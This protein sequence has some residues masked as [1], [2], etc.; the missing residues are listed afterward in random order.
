MVVVEKNGLE[1]KVSTGYSWKSLFF[2]IFY[3]ASR[4]DL[5]G[6]VIQLCL[7]FFTWGISWLFVPFKYNKIYLDRLISDGWKLKA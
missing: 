6:F 2:G 7:A 3:P 4:G 5:K 1:K